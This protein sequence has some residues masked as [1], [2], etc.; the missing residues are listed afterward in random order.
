MP[1]THSM[2]TSSLFRSLRWAHL[3]DPLQRM[4]PRDA[5]FLHVAAS[6][7]LTMGRQAGVAQFT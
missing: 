3:L 6:G 7:V 4:S 5:S 1:A 2:L